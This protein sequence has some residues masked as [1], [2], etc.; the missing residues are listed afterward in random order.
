MNT[1]NSAHD[2]S[3]KLSHAYVGTLTVAVLAVGICDIELSLVKTCRD[4]LMCD[5]SYDK[6]VFWSLRLAPTMFYVIHSTYIHAAPIE[7]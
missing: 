2:F 7:Y 6:S 4:L 5:N 3:V 1:N